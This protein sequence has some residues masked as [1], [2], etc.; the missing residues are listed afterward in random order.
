MV[1][2]LMCLAKLD[3]VGVIEDRMGACRRSVSFGFCFFVNCSFTT[4][5]IKLNSLSLTVAPDMFRLQ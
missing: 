1:L 5:S 2:L 3:D 4:N